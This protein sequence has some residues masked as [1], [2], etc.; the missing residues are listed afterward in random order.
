MK[1]QEKIVNILKELIGKDKKYKNSRELGVAL[2][3]TTTN[4]SQLYNLLN[5]DMNVGYKT[6]CDWFD[7]LNISLFETATCTE[8]FMENTQ[9]KNLS[10]NN[11][12]HSENKKV[13]ENNDLP[14][15]KRLSPNAPIDFIH[16]DN[17]QQIPVYG[18][19]GAGGEVELQENE[20][21]AVI[22]ILPEYNFSNMFSLKV[23]GDS[24]QPTIPKGSYVGV[25]P[26]FGDIQEGGIYLLER[27]HMGR[28]IK[29]IKLNED[30]MLYLF[31]DNPSYSPIPLDKMMVDGKIIGRVMWI[32]TM[33]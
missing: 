14:Y 19:T 18:F 9:N 22:S 28:M 8:N 11:N 30:G 32:L 23:E 2:G 3:L 26:N 20:P 13:N 17:L 25:T 6:V 24:M 10:F 29:R 21:I 12:T 5:K 15:I 7:I 33:P 27:V 4:I 16:G 31:S 1:N